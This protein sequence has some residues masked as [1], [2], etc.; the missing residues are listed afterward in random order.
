MRRL[1]A[2]LLGAAFA[3]VWAAPEAAA[4]VRASSATNFESR[5]ERAPDIDGVSWRV[6]PGGEYLE[7]TN[8]SA[9]A[10]VVLGYEGEPY[11]RIG[12]DGVHRNRNSPATYLNLERYGDVAIPPRADAAAEPDWERV[13]SDTRFAWHDHR[14]HWMAPEPPTAVAEAPGRRATVQEWSVPL[15]HAGERKAVEGV[16]TW[17]PGPP[18]WLWLVAGT[19]M[20]APALLGRRDGGRERLRPAA[21]VVAVVAALN[22]AHLPDEVMALPLP[23][24]DILFGI[25]HHL[26]FIGVGLAAALLALRQRTASVLALGIASGALLFH[27]GLL[28]VAQLDASQLATVWPPTV[29]RGLV[30]LSIGQALW[31]AVLIVLVLR[32]E[33][34][35]DPLRH[36]EAGQDGTLDP[37]VTVRSDPINS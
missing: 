4:H 17:E 28:Q 1:A 24:L 27:Q 23:T 37:L 16:L 2:I 3:L 26:L 18:W 14:I 5:I 35:Q 11:L 22:L 13:T 8:A 33:R 9:S 19:V 6:Y 12:P 32:A 7:V 36:A 31:C 15:E 29:I 21:V 25:L 34:S 20:T 30:A 10:V